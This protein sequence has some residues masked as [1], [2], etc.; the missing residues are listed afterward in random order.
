MDNTQNTND[1]SGVDAP[2]KSP[3]LR[4]QKKEEEHIQLVVFQLGGE[5]YALNIL[6]IREIMRTTSLTP[7]PNSPSFLAGIVNVRGQINVV[8][9]LKKRFHITGGGE[10]GH[11]INVESEGN[12]FGFLVDEVTEVM[13]LPKSMIEPA[14]PII[15]H[16]IGA[17][18]VTGVAVVE[19]R[20]LILLDITKILDEKELAQFSHVLHAQ[21]QEVQQAKTQREESEH[22]Q[23]SAEEKKEH[24]EK[25][26]RLAEQRVERH[27]NTEQSSPS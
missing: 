22:E 1:E 5:E 8:L 15:S 3:L 16:E 9:D 6:D 26:E 14:P 13:R 10:G 19:D 2:K 4:G 17:S 27:N 12:L 23:E 18:Y 21:E 7:V 11:I 25:V 20:L 24:Q